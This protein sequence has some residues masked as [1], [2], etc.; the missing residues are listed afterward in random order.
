MIKINELYI[1]VYTSTDI[2]E[3]KNKFSS[4]LNIITSYSNTKGKSTIGESILFCLGLEEILGNRDEKSVKP[5]LR[6]KIEKD[7][8]EHDVVQSDVFLEIENADGEIITILRSPKNNDRAARLV[9]VYENSIEEVLKDS[10]KF[11]DYYVH[12]PGATKNMRGFHNFLQK[13]INLDLPDVATYDGKSVKLY[14]QTLASCFYIEQKKGWMNV[15]ATLPTYYKIKDVKKRVLEFVM[16]LSVLETEREYNIR[17]AKLRDTESKWGIITDSITSKVR[18][19][20]GIEIEGLRKYPHIISEEEGVKLFIID[21]NDNKVE[22][23]DHIE[24]L[25]K[26]IEELNN[27]KEPTIENRSKALNRELNELSE[28]LNKFSI[29]ITDVRESY[30]MEKE[31]LDAIKDRLN[32]IRKDL[33]ENKDLK[34]IINLGSLEDVCITKSQCPT[35]KQEIDD[36][37]FEQNENLKIMTIEESIVHLESE[38]QM[39][40]FAIDAQQLIVNSKREFLNKLEVRVAEITSRI[41]VVKSDLISNNKAISQS[42]IQKIIELE[43]KKSTFENFIYDISELWE[44]LKQAGQE[45]RIDKSALDELPSDFITSKDRD[46]LD[47]LKSEFKRLL[48]VFK[49]ESTSIENIQI[50]DYNYLPNVEGFDLHSDSSAS[51]TIRIIWAYII[52]IQKVAK[53]SGNSL[54]FL[55]LDEPAQQNTDLS[56]TKKLL[57]ELVSLSKEQ[58]VFVFYKLESDD[59]FKDIEANDYYRIHTNDYLVRHKD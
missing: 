45:W 52:A 35:C 43:M 5:V 31:Q 3:F 22:L 57:S 19:V 41:R 4:G 1:R 51:D 27:K 55:V 28:L 24:Q 2:L 58:Q 59:L 37:L 17:K 13:F 26:Q 56:S 32:N 8:I 46:I 12:N 20:V 40:E 36:T 16:G 38:K 14:I 34:K 44:K 15:L 33:M 25:H 49:F 6:S 23:T 47:Y 53:K 11:Q 10:C 54:G 29:Q 18:K 7:G 30:L 21:D 9:S 48:R 42:Y 50:D 39:L